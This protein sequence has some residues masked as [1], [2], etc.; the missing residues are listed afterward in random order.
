[1]LGPVLSYVDDFV[2]AGNMASKYWQYIE[3][4]LLAAF[5]WSEWASAGFHPV[6]R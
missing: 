1:M 3:D 2:I 6:R 4:Q 5:D